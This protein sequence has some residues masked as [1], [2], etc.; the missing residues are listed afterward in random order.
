MKH[1]FLIMVF[2]SLFHASLAFSADP[3]PE[4]V[5]LKQKLTK[6]FESQGVNIDPDA[7]E[8]GALEDK[9]PFIKMFS[10][11]LMTLLV[12]V[13]PAEADAKRDLAASKEKRDDEKENKGF[14][15]A[16]NKNLLM[17]VI[18]MLEEN[19][20]KTKGVVEAFSKY[21]AK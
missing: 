7:T 9:T 6:H 1:I 21:N 13:Y 11:E 20:E 10:K 12:L 2:M 3:P 15:F 5:A 17:M 8:I 18:P 14:S 19:N 16:Q 4:L